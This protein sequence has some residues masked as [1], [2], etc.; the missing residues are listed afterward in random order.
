MERYNLKNDCKKREDVV[1]YLQNSLSRI[2]D[3]ENARENIDNCSCPSCPCADLDLPKPIYAA[4]LLVLTGTT[5]ILT[6]P[7]AR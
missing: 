1:K 6:L 4:G 5:P 2:Y 3:I 7:V